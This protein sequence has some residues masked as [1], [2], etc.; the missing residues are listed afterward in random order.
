MCGIS[1]FVD[2]NGLSDN[3]ILDKMI[4]ALHHRGPD[5]TGDY[6]IE[7]PEYQLGLGHKRLSILD[8]SSLGH[9]PMF[10]EDFVIVY[11]GEVYNF[12][13]IRDSLIKLG[14]QF[15]SQT[16]TEVILKAYCQWGDEMV[17][18]FNG[19]FA[20]SIYDKVKKE[21]TLIRD[22]AGIKPLYWYFKDGLFLF[23]SELKSMLEYPSL[24]REIDF[25]SLSLFLNYGYIKQPLS[26]YKDIFKLESGHI[27][28]LD[29]KSRSIRN[30]NFWN[31]LDCYAKEKTD[32]PE[33]VILNDLDSLLYSACNLRMVSDVPV[34]VFLS[35]GYDS[36]L[37]TALVQSGSQKKIKTFTIGFD[38]PKYNEASH[39]KAV[40]QHL[41]TEHFEY[42]CTEKDALDIIEELP[43]FWDE[44]FADSSAIPTFLVSKLAR[45]EVTVSLSADGGDELF[46]G[47]EKYGNSMVY[48]DFYKKYPPAKWISGVYPIIRDNFMDAGIL[49]G[50]LLYKMD[51]LIK[52]KNS[53]HPLLY[54]QN[55]QKFFLDNDIKKLSPKISAELLFN[56]DQLEN[57]H[58]DSLM[59][60]LMA[61]DYISYQADDILTKVD[62]ATMA[63]SLEGREPLL[64]YRLI[65]YVARIPADLKFKG[66]IKKYLLKEITHKYIPKKIMD[67]PKM[68]FSVPLVKW[69][70]TELLPYLDYYLGDEFLQNQNIFNRIEIKKLITLLKKHQDITIANRIWNLLV[71]QMW[72][73][74]W[75]K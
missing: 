60:G 56:Q 24:N 59:D 66:G 27:L 41:N 26:I 5:D 62:R 14:Y 72:Y 36:S 58:F 68:G 75:M 70:T 17:S 38:N 39:A 43:Y 8:L 18:K 65:E 42:I 19:M 35:G 15:I 20:I 33:D 4:Q 45:R 55:Y 74:K 28:K 49:K 73:E 52:N 67:R 22:R 13:E 71:F 53:D 21:L 9:Q 2:F 30:Y 11:N 57:F 23:A 25:K 12:V 34:G 37:V 7:E 10:Y 48:H 31:V 51:N 32:L 16:D 64:D 47:Y 46:G 54:F 1:G 6:F 50:P 40:A 69:L 29:L 61:F 3:S 63:N 44:P